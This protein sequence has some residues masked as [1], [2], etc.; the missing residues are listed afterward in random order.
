MIINVNSHGS[1]MA[2]LS[3]I[4][5][6]FKSDLRSFIYDL[7]DLTAVPEQGASVDVLS[8]QYYPFSGSIL[9]DGKTHNYEFGCGESYIDIESLTLSGTTYRFRL[10]YF[11][12]SIKA[13]IEHINGLN[14]PYSVKVQ[15]TYNIALPQVQDRNE[16]VYQSLST[17]IGICSKVKSGTNTEYITSVSGPSKADISGIKV[18]TSRTLRG[19]TDTIY[20]IGSCTT[21]NVAKKS[22]HA[23]ISNRPSC[24]ELTNNYTLECLTSEPQSIPTAVQFNGSERTEVITS[25]EYSTNDG[26]L[27]LSFVSPFQF[28]NSGNTIKVQNSYV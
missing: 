3:A 7:G 9:T 17:L 24:N 18:V 27:K 10:Y 11:S 25:Y 1:S 15:T 13:T 20:Q 28:I 5:M 6:P 12:R 16:S 8:H 4:K 22:S 2:Q 23:L 21:Y 19:D 26:K 14:S